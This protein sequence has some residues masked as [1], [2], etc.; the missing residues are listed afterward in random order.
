M[1]KKINFFS[2]LLLFFALF[3]G[4][5]N[6]ALAQTSF[7]SP[8]DLGILPLGIQNS[9]NNN[10]SINGYTNAY[11]GA[12][13]QA[14]NDV[15][16]KIKTGACTDRLVISTCSA[17][18]TLDTYIH[19]LDASGTEI[20]S[21]DNGGGC[22]A[23]VGASQISAVVAPST[24]Y[25]IVVEGAGATPIEGDF[26]L[27]M[28]SFDDVVFSIVPSAVPPVA[29]VTNS[30]NLS[31]VPTN[32][33]GAI[34]YA[35]AGATNGVTGTGSPFTIASAALTDQDIYD[36]VATDG[37]G[38]TATNFVFLTVNAAPSV[39]PSPDISICASATSVVIDAIIGGSATTGTWSFSNPGGGSLSSTTLSGMGESY[40]VTGSDLTGPFPKNIVFTI[41]TDAPTGC[42]AA[43]GTVTLT[44]TG[45]PDLVTTP[46]A[47]VCLGSTVDLA[48]T[49][50][51][52]A[53][54]LLAGT[55]TWYPTEL[56]AQTETNA[57]ASTIVTPPVGTTTYWVRKN[58]N[59]SNC[60]DI[61][62]VDVTVNPLPTIT[63]GAVTNVCQ[64]A[65]SFALPYTA[66]TATPNQYTITAGT[67]ALAGFVPVTLAALPATPIAVAIPAGSAAG[68][69]SFDIVVK[70]STTGCLS[71]P[72]TFSV[73]I[74][75][76][77]T[78]TIAYATPFCSNGTTA[79][80]TQT[81]NTG[82]T[83]SST[84]GL[85]INATTGEINIATSTPATYTVTYTIAA[86]GSCPAVVTTT[87]ITITPLAVPTVAYATPVCLSGGNQTPTSFTP[88]GGSFSID[89][90]GAIN[91]TTGVIAIPTTPA[92]TYTV[93]YT[94]PATGGCAATSST[95]PITITT[96][97]TAAISYATPFCSNGTT[98][99]PT[100]TGTGAGGTYSSTA[101]LNFVSTATGEINIAT[102]TPGTYVI[103]YDLAAAAGCPAVTT[104][105]SITITPLAVPTVAYAT[106]VCLSG[107]NQTP[108]SFT[109]VGGS[110]SI[111]G[112][113]SINATTGVIA[114]PTTP[115]GTYTVTYT[116]PATGGCAATSST[117]PI[118][119]TT[120]LT[121][122]IS[123]AT[124]FCANGTTALPTFTG[125][126][127]GGTYS[128]TTGLTIDG[129][130]GEINIATSTPGTYTVTYDLAA[131]AGCPAVVATT[132]ILINA[133]PTAT[134]AY[135]TP[136]FCTSTLPATLTAAV[137][138]TGTT[139]G[140]YS[141]TPA[142]LDINT[143]TGLLTLATSTPGTYT[144]TYSFV[145]PTTGCTNN[146]TTT[147]TINAA[148]TPTIVS[149]T[150]NFTPC[151]TDGVTSSSIT[152]S[153]AVTYSSYA[154]TGSLG[155]GGVATNPT[156]PTVNQG[157]AL[158]VQ[159]YTVQVT[160]ANGCK[161][162]TNVNVTYQA[163]PAAS[164]I[165]A[166][167]TICLG[168]STTVTA[169]LT[170]GTTFNVTWSDGLV[171]TAVASPVI[172]TFSPTINTTYSITALTNGTC[173]AAASGLT[174]AASV[175]VNAIGP[176][177]VVVPN[178]V[179][180]CTGTPFTLTP[181]VTPA[182]VPQSFTST[183]DFNA[184]LTGSAPQVGS[185]AATVA[186][187]GLSGV[188][189]PALTTFGTLSTTVNQGG[190]CTAQATD[191]VS[192]TGASAPYAYSQANWNVGDYY[193]ARVSAKP[194]FKIG[195]TSFSFKVRRSGSGP[196]TVNVGYT[197]DGGALQTV[198]TAQAVSS[199]AFSIYNFV[200][201]TPIT[202]ATD[203]R[204]RVI[205]NVASTGATA[206]CSTMRIDDIVVTGTST[207]VP[208]FAYYNDPNFIPANQVGTGAT[209]T[210]TAGATSPPYIYVVE[211]SGACPSDTTAV[212]IIVNTPP[213]LTSLTPLAVCVGNPITLEGILGTGVTPVPTYTW[214][215]PN[216]AGVFEN[217][218]DILSAALT[219]AGTYTVTATNVCGTVTTSIVLAV[220]ALPVIQSVDYIC[221]ST[222]VTVVPT[223]PGSYTYTWISQVG[224]VTPSPTTNTTGSFLLG[225]GAAQATFTITNGN[226]CTS[227]QYQEIF[228]PCPV[229]PVKLTYFKGRVQGSNDLL[230][231]G[232]ASEINSAWFILEGSNDGI[233]F[234]EV[235]RKR[236]AGNSNVP[237]T[238]AYTNENV[239]QSTYYRLRTIDLDGS[240][241]MSNTVY[242]RRNKGSLAVNNVFPNPTEG[243]ITVQYEVEKASKLQFSIV[244]ELGRRLSTKI[245]E[246]VSG[247]NNQVLDLADFPAGMYLLLIDE[248]DGKRTI[249][250]IVKN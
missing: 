108:T 111:D 51:D 241:E 190:A 131:A 249:R 189:S 151:V 160:D 113:G 206:V 93:T 109:P 41:T 147:V 121:A 21:N 182:P 53:M 7:G 80:V 235:G 138:L 27:I 174:S 149:S 155:T 95:A 194:N 199:T 60:F 58:I 146:T 164:V 112:A 29:C 142:G 45:G 102:S 76:I 169:T 222:N 218:N 123:Y 154:W 211:T 90:A 33:V 115:S 227:S 212:P 37:A 130:S 223:T 44:I 73:T 137:T 54:P 161:A 202:N 178:P 203:I 79:A 82:G 62:S 35:W 99:L 133:L 65:T 31:A 126:G 124:P 228:A 72:V 103:T 39:A 220:N 243:E 185:L 107:G 141:A 3:L 175:I 163:R 186:G 170:P 217:T 200:L 24:F 11:T 106:P 16:Y 70:N 2:R 15:F 171:Q 215:G 18:T 46:P 152:L 187:P 61:A 232:T 97:L 20:A 157:V 247:V 78:A 191:W 184:A 204:F 127:A 229:L 96:P 193:E 165:A 55:T 214:A 210:A 86:A 66:T 209:Y 143:T 14:S 28:E 167:T 104:T 83:Y 195:A 98:A 94:M 183:Y 158:P 132:S 207:N 12:T 34:T 205:A 148:P 9:V 30:V 134:I 32:G 173:P 74:D 84:A 22:A 172:R 59:I 177:P 242:L 116:M 87:S 156:I 69:Y 42:T 19:L 68:T 114:I 77:P 48:L 238:Y 1:C 5:S 105:T 208:A 13:N 248:T 236:A 71:T 10:E 122:A 117:A 119:I 101:G 56:D 237:L 159:P 166:P 219:D 153:T 110:F 233:S 92:G 145:S 118:T 85:M 100:F 63:L 168:Q 240:F 196:A 239:V 245:I 224:G 8:A 89:G 88:V 23:P 64:G 135:A 144:V 128:S 91:A 120:P 234:K 192:G 129:T 213:T 4:L 188:T 49:V 81:G 36:V 75:P 125:T 17:T 176:K 52:I 140:T 231:W 244:D 50:T 162:S 25:Y 40:N 250:K 38:C 198:A 67:P 226:N 43:T 221:T 57:L 136:A 181:A 6:M 246:A 180:V 197:V 201:A 26:D 47:A 139:G 225:Q 150:G 216:L 179:R 230:E